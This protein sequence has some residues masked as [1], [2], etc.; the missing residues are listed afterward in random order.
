[1]LKILKQVVEVANTILTVTAIKLTSINKE[2]EN[3]LYYW[4]NNQ[5]QNYKNNKGL[6]KDENRRQPKAL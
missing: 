6:M 2:E 4:K 5:K 1:M 3:Y